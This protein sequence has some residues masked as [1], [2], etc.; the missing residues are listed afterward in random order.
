[1]IVLFAA[2]GEIEKDYSF[3]E[4]NMDLLEQWSKYLIRYGED[5]DYQLCTDDFAGHLSHNCNL[6]LKAIMGIAGYARILR[7]LGRTVEAEEYMQVAKKY[8]DSFLT[9]AANADGSYRLAYDRPDT[10]S[11]KYNAIWDKLWNTG[12]FPDSFYAGEMARY[13]K[14]AQ[15]YGVPLDTREM[16]TKSDWMHWVSCFGDKEDFCFMN[17]LLFKAYNT[18]RAGSRVP[19][20]D[21]FYADTTVHQYFQH[22]TVQGGLFLKFLF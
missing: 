18:M 17:D 11:L 20:S 7:A 12:L 6:S 4:A 13:R 1:M 9:R 8:A 19:M 2:L 21:W 16:Y 5:P 10:F 15:P 3:A 14:E 22:R